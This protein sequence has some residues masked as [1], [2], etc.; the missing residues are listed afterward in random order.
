MLLNLSVR[1]FKVAV[2]KCSTKEA[3]N[4]L[5]SK[6]S[7]MQNYRGN[8]GR[9]MQKEWM[10]RISKRRC[11]MKKTGFKH[12]AIFIG[13][14]L[15]WSLLLIQLQTFRSATLLKWDCTNT[16]FFCKYWNFL[17]TEAW[18]FIKKRLQHRCFSVNIANGCFCLFKSNFVQF[19]HFNCLTLF[20]EAKI[21]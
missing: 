2:L 3:K 5:F 19:N 4:Q 12:F 10:L 13:K 6:R 9:I 21:Q 18:D 20:K 7:E 8:C 1:P 15:Y 17:R 11:S 14:H 16:V